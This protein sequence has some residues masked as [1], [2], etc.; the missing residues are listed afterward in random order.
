MYTF[1]DETGHVTD[2]KNM[3]G[4]VSQQPSAPE[5]MKAC[6]DVVGLLSGT[7]SAEAVPVKVVQFQETRPREMTQKGQSSLSLHQS[8][9]RGKQLMHVS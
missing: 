8:K 5:T 7:V 1:D 9:N 3:T 2:N 4:I 6:T